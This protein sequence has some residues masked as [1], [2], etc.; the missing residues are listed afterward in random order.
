[1]TR[2]DLDRISARM[3]C[4]KDPEE[5]EERDKLSHITNFRKGKSLS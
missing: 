5:T 3:G 2:R 4:H 1:M